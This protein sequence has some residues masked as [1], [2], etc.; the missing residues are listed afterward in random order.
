M[1][2][3]LKD[4]HDAFALLISHILPCDSSNAKSTNKIKINKFNKEHPNLLIHLTTSDR[5]NHHCE[6][7]EGLRES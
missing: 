5:S 4:Q 2:N 7:E 1:E 6:E 3:H